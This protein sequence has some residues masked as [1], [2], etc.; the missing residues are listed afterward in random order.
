MESW[1]GWPLLSGEFNDA[2]SDIKALDYAAAGIAAVV[3]DVPAYS[4]P[5]SEGTFLRAPHELFG[6]AVM[7]LIEDDDFRNK[8][9]ASAHQ[10]LL[11][12]QTIADISPKLQQLIESVLETSSAFE[13]QTKSTRHPAPNSSREL[14]A[15]GRET[16]GFQSKPRDTQGFGQKFESSNS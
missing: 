9:I 7:Q 4:I 15:N 12:Q 3:A 13:V 10:Y 16:W 11:D 8:M 6:T 5:G 1:C 14:Q 2:K